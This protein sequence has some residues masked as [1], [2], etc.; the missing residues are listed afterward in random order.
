[1]GPNQAGSK[2]QGIIGVDIDPAKLLVC[3]DLMT[4][5]CPDWR[6]KHFATELDQV[7]A[8]ELDQVLTTYSQWQLHN[9]DAVISS[10]PS[11]NHLDSTLTDGILA[12]LSELSSPSGKANFM[13][14]STIAFNTNPSTVPGYGQ[15]ELPVHISYALLGGTDHKVPEQIYHELPSPDLTY[16][17]HPGHE[18]P[19][20]TYYELPGE[21]HCE[22]PEPT[23]YE[24]PM[25]TNNELSGHDP[26]D[27]TPL[28]L[29]DFDNGR[30]P[31]D[32]SSTQCD[33]C[34]EVIN[35]K[36]RDRRSNLKRHQD[37]VCARKNRFRCPEPDCDEFFPRAD[38]FKAHI[39]KH[40]KRANRHT[41]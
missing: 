12:P 19:D 3:D 13:T 27:F 2:R 7:L 15:G 35:S 17:E 34:G 32:S 25:N 5:A 20:K 37:T 41:I 11:G 23:R 10:C 36:P 31:V 38:Y 6:E 28:K 4:S 29:P 14:D 1:M 30:L 9:P 8:T 24:L 21:I 18:C 26:S 22:L 16:H 40:K 33:N 39:K